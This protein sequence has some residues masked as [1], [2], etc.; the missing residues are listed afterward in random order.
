MMPLDRQIAHDIDVGAG[1]RLDALADETQFG[2]LRDIEEVRRLE[3]SHRGPPR[4]SRCSRRRSSPRRWPSR[5]RRLA[6]ARSPTS[7]Q[8][9]RAPSRS[10][11]AAPKSAR[12]SGCCRFP[13]A[14]FSWLLL[15]AVSIRL[16]A[17][18]VAT[19]VPGPTRSLFSITYGISAVW[20]R[21]AR[22]YRNDRLDSQFETTFQEDLMRAADLD[23]HE[24]L[25]F[26]PEGGII[27]FARR[28]R[29][30]ARRG[31]AGSAQKRAHRHA[32]DHGGAGS[33]SPGSG[34][35]TDGASRK[36]CA[37][38]FPGTAKTS[39]AP[40][41]RGFIRFRARPRGSDARVGQ[42]RR[43]R[44]GGYLARLVRGRAASA[45]SRPG[46][47][48]GVLDADGLR[49]RLHVVRVRQGDHRHRGSLP[50]QRRRGLP[51][52]RPLKRRVGAGTR[53]APPLL[54]EGGLP[55]CRG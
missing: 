36:R 27:T 46:G 50:R 35:R 2:I 14:R 47:R 11:G 24:L 41:A 10:P 48:A 39:G 44:R 49:Q 20:S 32:R 26:L 34:M 38:D 43:A 45:A 5:S 6:P 29:A 22:D 12:S 4:P 8:T 19:A 3:M 16:N 9:S 42:Q 54:P 30:P 55:G 52:S 25:H 21:R 37:R 40:P 51:R 18:P 33:S 28:A 7:A 23:V 17:D 53:D 13:N 1:S 15:V 31:R